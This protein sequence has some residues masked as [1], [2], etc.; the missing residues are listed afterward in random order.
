MDK[1]EDDYVVVT[2]FHMAMFIRIKNLF[3]IAWILIF[4]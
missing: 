1:F 2:N 3:F 4:I